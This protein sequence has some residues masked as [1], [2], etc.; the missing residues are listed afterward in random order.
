MICHSKGCRNVTKGGNKLC[1]TCKKRKYR[2]ENPLKASFQSLKDNAKRRNKEFNLT[3][4]EFK[5]FSI[6]TDYYK[7]KGISSES[8]HIDRIDE[9]KGYLINN[10][11]VLT[12]SQNVK[13]YLKYRYDPELRKMEFSNEIPKFQTSEN[14]PF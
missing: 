8:F 9:S 11:Q 7:K 10:I 3:F 6:K 12:N 2:K 1:D 13:K 4:D 14:C 5:E